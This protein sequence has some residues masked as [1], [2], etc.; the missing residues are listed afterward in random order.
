MTV[1]Y[2]N[3]L[4]FQRRDAITEKQKQADREE[5]ERLHREFLAKGGTVTSLPPGHA[6]GDGPIPDSI[7]LN[8]FAGADRARTFKRMNHRHA[9][10]QRPEML[11]LHQSGHTPDEIAN[12]L[13][14]HKSTVY[15]YLAT[16]REE[17]P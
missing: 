3:F 8:K 15:A 7:R 5:A 1:T 14:V 12:K 16:L 6:R 10:E 2:N 4:D 9:A 17:K 11:R 13:H